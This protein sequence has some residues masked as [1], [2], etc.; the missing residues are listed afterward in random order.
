M[1]LSIDQLLTWLL[2]YGYPVLFAVVFVGS[3]G[4][5]IPNNL[6][7]LAAGGLAADGDL[8]LRVVVAVVLFAAI[9]GDCL[10]YLVARW[11]GERTVAR[12]GAR[13]GL[14]KERLA[15]VRGRFGAW[16]GMG[17]FLTR[18]LLT[19]LAFP[20]GVLAGVGRYSTAAY[21]AAVVAGELLWTGAYVGLGYAFGD[22]WSGILDTVQDSLGLVVGLC[23]VLIAGGLLVFTQLRPTTR[24][25]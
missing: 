19:P 11:A 3:L 14:G 1:S 18:W 4:A 21:C 15:A 22:S 7:L 9:L 8:D 24:A 16:L 6:L 13:I 5:P 17:V 12:H 2:V 25:R 23:L 10:V 20:A